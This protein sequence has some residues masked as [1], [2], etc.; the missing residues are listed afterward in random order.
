M[1]SAEE[2]QATLQQ[3]SHRQPERLTLE[4]F[5]ERE[6]RLQCDRERESDGRRQQSSQLFNNIQFK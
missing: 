4:T 1:Q 3:M 6:V 2:R 5:D